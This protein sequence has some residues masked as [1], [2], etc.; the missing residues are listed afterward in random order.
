VISYEN[1][2]SKNFLQAWQLKTTTFC[3]ELTSHSPPPPPLLPAL[4]LSTGE[5]KASEGESKVSRSGPLPHNS[6]RSSLEAQNGLLHSGGL[7]RLLPRRHGGATGV[8]FRTHGPRRSPPERYLNQDRY[9]LPEYTISST[10]VS[11]LHYLLPPLWQGKRPPQT[12]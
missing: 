12:S 10:T 3:T 8:L 11:L 2:C 9:L 5:H 4:T 1:M 6:T 7:S